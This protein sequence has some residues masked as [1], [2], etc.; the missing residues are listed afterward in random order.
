MSLR[1]LSRPFTAYL[2]VISAFLAGW[3]KSPRRE[4]ER[5]RHKRE[6]EREERARGGTQ[7]LRIGFRRSMNWGLSFSRAPSGCLIA[8]VLPL[9]LTSLYSSLRFIPHCAWAWIPPRPGLE[10]WSPLYCQIHQNRQMSSG[11]VGFF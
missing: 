11:K 7:G 5:S 2:P 10:W 4:E 8:V 3:G 6:R 1:L 9:I